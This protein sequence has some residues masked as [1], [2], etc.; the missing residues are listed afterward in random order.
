MQKTVIV[1]AHV[2]SPAVDLEGATVV[3]EGR[4]ISQVTARRVAA[5]PDAST[6]VARPYHPG[7]SFPPAEFHRGRPVVAG[8]HQCCWTSVPQKH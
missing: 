7:V 2:I 8:P 4:R 3:I 6:T 5:R 1:N